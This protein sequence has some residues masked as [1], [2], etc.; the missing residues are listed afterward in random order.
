MLSNHRRERTYYEVIEY[1]IGQNNNIPHVQEIRFAWGD[2]L[3]G[4]FAA[5]QAVHDMEIRGNKIRCTFVYLRE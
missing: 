2:S 3:L 1:R 4:I 5:T